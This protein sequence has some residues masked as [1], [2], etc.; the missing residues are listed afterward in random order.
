M[1]Y[2]FAEMRFP[3]RIW[4]SFMFSLLLWPMWFGLVFSPI[5]SSF[6]NV[7]NN[8]FRNVSGKKR[9]RHFIIWHTYTFKSLY[10]A[11]PFSKPTLPCVLCLFAFNIQLNK[12]KCQRRL[13]QLYFFF[14][15]ILF[16]FF[17]RS[18]STRQWRNKA[19]KENS[20]KKTGEKIKEE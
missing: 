5:L 11:M 1:W 12:C 10:L 17:F 20:N 13:Y 15:R 3:L 4:V 14:Y 16:S 19:P 8:W 9:N 7:S 18:I 2:R 6:N